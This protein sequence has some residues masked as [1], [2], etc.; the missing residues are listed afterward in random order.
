MKLVIVFYIH[1]QAG[2]RRNFCIARRK[3]FFV[4]IQEEIEWIIWIHVDEDQIRIVHQQ[5]AEAETIVLEGHV[6]SRANIFHRLG[7]QTSK[8]LNNSLAFDSY[9][10]HLAFNMGRRQDL[11][12]IK[13]Q[14]VL[15]SMHSRNLAFFD[16][17]A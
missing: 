12:K 9:R 16:Q 17:R 8:D 15:L 4:V 2:V 13:D 14:I 1:S 5:L 3:L 10:Y 11:L 6:I 7:I